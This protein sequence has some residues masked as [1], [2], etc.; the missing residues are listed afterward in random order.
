M[1][2]PSL[3]AL[4]ERNDLKMITEA[5]GNENGLRE[6][7]RQEIEQRE[8]NDAH[9]SGKRSVGQK[10]LKRP[11]NEPCPVQIPHAVFQVPMKSNTK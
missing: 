9:E 6:E 7:W 3:K 2:N 4:G 10:A 11:G 1:H 5:T 8:N